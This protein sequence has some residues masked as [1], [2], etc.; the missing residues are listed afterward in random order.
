MVHMVHDLQQHPS[1]RHD[2]PLDVWPVGRVPTPQRVAPIEVGA[3]S[4][5][6]NGPPWHFLKLRKENDV[7][8]TKVGDDKHYIC[9]VLSCCVMFNM[10][11]FMD[12]SRPPLMILDGAL[13]YKCDF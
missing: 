5:S 10:F 13:E 9:Y 11:M 7:F 1:T 2:L 12:G 4:Q 3:P 8:M 6:E